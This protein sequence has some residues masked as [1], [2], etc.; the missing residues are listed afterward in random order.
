MK[1]KSPLWYKTNKFLMIILLLGLI[2]IGC[3]PGYLLYQNNEK[4]A[5]LRKEKRVTDQLL[6]DYHG[7]KFSEKVRPTEDELEQLQ[8]KLP[9]QLNMAN[10]LKQIE[11]RAT[12]AGISWKSAY[13]ANKLDELDQMSQQLDLQKESENKE[14][15]GATKVLSR[16]QEKP[17]SAKYTQPQLSSPYLKLVWADLYFVADTAELKSFFDQIR[18]S[19]STFVI[20]EWEHQVTDIQG[21]DG[22]TRVRIGFYSYL[23]PKLK[24]SSPGDIPSIP[25]SDES[26]QIIP[27]SKEKEDQKEAV[28]DLNQENTKEKEEEKSQSESDTP[29]ANDDPDEENVGTPTTPAS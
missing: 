15:I 17:T 29:E 16:I 24:I 11:E 19:A 7:G 9:D 28:D 18:E 8:L 3:G 4:L 2:A 10:A 21:G 12:S 23:N 5:L 13:F 20:V 26:I 22:N 25:T 27:P 14:E 6:Q 1:L